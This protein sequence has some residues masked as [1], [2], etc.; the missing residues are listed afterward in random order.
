MRALLLSLF[1][2]VAISA[3]VLMPVA[4]EDGPPDA[5]DGDV[6]ALDEG[7]QYTATTLY[8][9]SDDMVADVGQAQGGSNPMTPTRPFM[10]V[11]DY[12]LMVGSRDAALGDPTAASWTYA[13]PVSQRI[14]CWAATWHDKGG[15]PAS[16]SLWIDGTRTAAVDVAATGLETVRTSGPSSLDV[17]GDGDLALQI[18][19]DLGAV[20]FDATSAPSSLTYVV[21]EEIPAEPDVLVIDI[22]YDPR[23]LTVEAG[24]TVIWAWQG[25]IPHDVRSNGC[26]Q[27]PESCLFDSGVQTATPNLATR[28]AFTFDEPGTY[29]YYC[30]LHSTPGGTAHNGTIVVT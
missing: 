14:V 1:L 6:P 27:G 11:A 18:G 7:E 16:V 4:A 26:A 21:I 29:D 3:T 12:D 23:M 17:T 24:S 5:C 8:F 2:V 22:D 28:F 9:H 19:A 13:L 10:S 30:S 25:N 20:A 15:Q